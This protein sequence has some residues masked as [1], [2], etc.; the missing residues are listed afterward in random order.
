MKIH[1]CAFLLVLGGKIF[2]YSSLPLFFRWVFRQL[3]FG[4]RRALFNLPEGPSAHLQQG[5]SGL[6]GQV[7]QGDAVWA[8]DDQHCRAWWVG[9]GLGWVESDV[10][11]LESGGGLLEF[12][13]GWVESGVGGWSVVVYIII[14]TNIEPAFDSVCVWSDMARR[15]GGWWEGVYIV[16][17]I[18]RSAGF[19]HLEWRA[20]SSSVHGLIPWKPG[21]G[22]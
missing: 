2:N 18:H 3:F 11:W 9:S 12:G 7:S 21:K 10:G 4:R 6:Q 5:V 22:V 1:S 17:V 14:I 19:W 13:V 20:R 15:V 8:Q 16:L